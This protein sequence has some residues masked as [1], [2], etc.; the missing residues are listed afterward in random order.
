MVECKDHACD[1][2]YL[3]GLLPCVH[4]N[5]Y[6]ASNGPRYIWK[7]LFFD[8]ALSKSVSLSPYKGSMWTPS[9]FN[10]KLSRS[11]NDGLHER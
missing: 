11:K 3:S 1:I 6:S 10:A 2:R 9:T 5:G 8:R 4:S 7:D